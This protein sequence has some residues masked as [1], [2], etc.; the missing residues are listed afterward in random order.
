MA[1]SF[2]YKVL[3]ARWGFSK[4]IDDG[5]VSVFSRKRTGL[6]KKQKKKQ[7]IHRTMN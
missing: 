6:K 4:R 3:K 1:L 5:L 2:K 7:L